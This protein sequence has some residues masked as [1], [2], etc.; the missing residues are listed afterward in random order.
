MA[1]GSRS[2]LVG[3]HDQG[4]PVVQFLDG[5]KR[6]QVNIDS[7]MRLMN[8]VK[9]SSISLTLKTGTYSTTRV[10][11]GYEGISGY[12]FNRGSLSHALVLNDNIVMGAGWTVFENVIDGHPSRW[13]HATS[14]HGEFLLQHV[15]LGI[16][17][18]SL[19]GFSPVD[20]DPAHML[21]AGAS[22]HID[23]ATSLHFEWSRLY[24]NSDQW[25]TGLHYAPMEALEFLLSLDITNQIPAMGM[26]LRIGGNIVVIAA[27]RLH[28]LLGE[29]WSLGLVYFR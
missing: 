11:L 14:L 5:D 12:G 27:T 18:T 26:A 9:S 21:T 22:Y 17:L 10:A 7:G 23:K 4:R 3:Y 19:Y 6:W 15:H 8:E 2:L 16:S 13:M 25:T 20:A 1:S 29:E 28:A 24:D